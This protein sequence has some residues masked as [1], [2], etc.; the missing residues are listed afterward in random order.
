MR[1]LVLALILAFVDPVF[2]AGKT[3]VYKYEA[4]LLAGLLEKGSARAGLNI[5][6]KVSI[7]ANDQNTY[8]IKLEEPELQQYSGIWPEDPFI[9]ATELT[10]SLQ[11]E[12]T[13]PIKFEYVNGA[14]GKV[15][16]PETVSTTVRLLS[17]TPSQGRRIH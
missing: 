7:N 8:F 6:S 12:L 3:Y 9:P 13:T 2:E 14:V 10:S 17:Q 5:S 4:L 1:A 11:A 15:F 16:A